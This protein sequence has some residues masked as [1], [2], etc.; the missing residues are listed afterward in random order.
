MKRDGDLRRLFIQRMPH[1]QWTSIETG[2]I[3][4]DVPD[5]ELVLTKAIRDGS[6]FK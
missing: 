2:A 1:A 5:T 3:T 4:Q 6:K